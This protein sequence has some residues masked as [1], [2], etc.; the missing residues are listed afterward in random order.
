M[1][2]FILQ[3]IK[4]SKLDGVSVDF[5]SIPEKSQKDMLDFVQLLST[6]FHENHLLVTINLP[7]GDNNFDYKKYAE[8]P[9]YIIIMAYDEHWSTSE[10]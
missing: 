3:Y 8:Y 6:S 4:N 1:V 5:E 7:A 2:D 10:A 9:D